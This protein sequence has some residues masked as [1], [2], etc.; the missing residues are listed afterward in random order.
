MTAK[1]KTITKQ[2]EAAINNAQQQV[3]PGVKEKQKKVMKNLYLTPEQNEL[4]K[5]LA[6]KKGIAV[7]A[8]LRL[9]IDK[10]INENSDT[11]I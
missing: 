1:F 9:L 6:D 10:Y 3:N 2:Q 11:L 8:L 4:L 5:K 7:T